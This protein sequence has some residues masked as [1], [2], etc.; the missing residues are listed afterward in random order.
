MAETKEMSAVERIA[1]LK[2]ELQKESTKLLSELERLLAKSA[3]TYR[4]FLDSVGSQDALRGEQFAQSLSTL[5]L[6]IKDAQK[7]IVKKESNAPKVTGSPLANKICEALKKKRQPMD[8]AS[9]I[10]S[11]EGEA[12]ATTVKQYAQRLVSEG[13]LYRPERGLFAI[14]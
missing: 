3:D 4:V 12:K 8:I 13:T 6:E 2:N 7:P 9:L 11:L 1:Q 5:G 10:K 14:K